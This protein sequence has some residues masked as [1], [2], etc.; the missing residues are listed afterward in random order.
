MDL[1]NIGFEDVDWIY[2]TPDI[3]QWRAVVSNISSIKESELSN[4]LNDP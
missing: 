2:L 4:Y 3:V 1:K